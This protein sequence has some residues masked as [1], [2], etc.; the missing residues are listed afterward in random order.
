MDCLQHQVRSFGLYSRC[1]KY[2]ELNIE[3]IILFAAQC[4]LFWSTNV[5]QVGINGT[6]YNQNKTLRTANR[7][8]MNASLIA[9]A[10]LYVKPKGRNLIEKM[11]QTINQNWFRKRRFVKDPTGYDFFI[12]HLSLQTVLL[13]FLSFVQGVSLIYRIPSHSGE[14]L[15]PVRN[16]SGA[17][18]SPSVKKQKC[19]KTYFTKNLLW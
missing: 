10:A 2:D 9:F 7:K 1:R 6:S 15:F 19:Y 17:N 4:V 5:Q 13:R 14:Q 16:V 18:M 3:T 8:L 12:D 11:I